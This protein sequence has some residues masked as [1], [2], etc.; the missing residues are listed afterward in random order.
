MRDPNGVLFTNCPPDREKFSFGK[1]LADRTS[2]CHLLELSPGWNSTVPSSTGVLFSHV[3][4][5]PFLVFYKIYKEPSAW[6]A[7]SDRCLVVFKTC[8]AK[9]FCAVWYFQ[10]SFC[11]DYGAFCSKKSLGKPRPFF[12]LLNT[13]LIFRFSLA[14]LNRIRA[15][16]RRKRVHNSNRRRHWSRH[17]RNRCSYRS[18]ANEATTKTVFRPGS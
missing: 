7:K 2:L 6:T 9:G 11:G 13:E 8:P 3:V 4:Y 1:H 14:R 15:P 12:K 10:L 5:F 18:A 16:H 17:A